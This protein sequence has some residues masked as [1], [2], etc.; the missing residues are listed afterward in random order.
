MDGHD[1]RGRVVALEQLAASREPRM[2]ALET[3]QRQADIFNA[4]QDVKFQQ[5]ETDL[6]K[7]NATLSRIMWLIVGGMI[8][9]I[10][11]F[12]MSGGFKVP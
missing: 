7:I 8:A 2:I 9:G 1:L 4:R 11:S 6:K 3:W 5:I 12:M 10:M